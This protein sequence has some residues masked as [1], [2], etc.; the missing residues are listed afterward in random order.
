MT[1]L[2]TYAIRSADAAGSK[3]LDWAAMGQSAFKVLLV[4][5]VFGAGLPACYALGMK[6][7]DAGTATVREDGTAT[8]TNPLALTGAALAFAV[9][10]AAVGCGLLLI[11]SKTIKHYTGLEITFP[12]MG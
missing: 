5:L 4:G 11:M 2:T 1:D 12:G 3:A 10:L 8:R 6:L 9:V 7:W